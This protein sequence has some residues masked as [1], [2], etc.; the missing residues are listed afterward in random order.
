[1]LCA[2]GMRPR[3]Y[4]EGFFKIII[5]HCIASTHNTPYFTLFKN[6]FPKLVVCYFTPLLTHSIQFLFYY[7]LF[8][9]T[10]SA[11]FQNISNSSITN[12]YYFGFYYYTDSFSASQ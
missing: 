12:S 7:C 3:F 4:L 5:I 9:N 10:E 6:S 8:K 1:M 11:D 2:L